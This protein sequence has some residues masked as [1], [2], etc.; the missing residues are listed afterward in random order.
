[1]FIATRKARPKGKEVDEETQVAIASSSL[2][3]KYMLSVDYI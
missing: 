1:M 2:L 3:I